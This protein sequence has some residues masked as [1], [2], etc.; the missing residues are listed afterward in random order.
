MQAPIIV[1]D[2]KPTLAKS[3]PLSDALIVL[4]MTIETSACLIIKTDSYNPP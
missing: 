1:D 3:P 2:L 4:M